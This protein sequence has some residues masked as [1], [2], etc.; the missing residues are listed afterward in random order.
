MI[1]KK[2]DFQNFVVQDPS[3]NIL[4]TG[5]RCAVLAIAPSRCGGPVNDNEQRA[6][7]FYNAFFDYEYVG[8]GRLN[9]RQQQN[10]TKAF[11]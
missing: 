5:I 10:I 8:F 3:C 4:L 2:I 7:A 9:R 6:T 11:D 1:F